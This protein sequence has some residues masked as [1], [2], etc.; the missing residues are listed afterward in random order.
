MLNAETNA[1][2]RLF[3]RA[4]QPEDKPELTYPLMTGF[5]ENSEFRLQVG[6]FRQ[7]NSKT[8]KEFLSLSVGNAG[9]THRFSGTLHRDEKVGKEGHYYGYISESVVVGEDQ[10][11]PVFESGEWQLLVS[12]KRVEPEGKKKYIGGDVYPSKKSSDSAQS[13]ADEEDLLF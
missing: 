2:I 7:V 13:V 8:Q 3:N 10:G 6:A 4:P 12:A 1:V 9:D 11:K 5:I